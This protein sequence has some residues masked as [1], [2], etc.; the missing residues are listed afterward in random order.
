MS[1]APGTCRGWREGP[2][3]PDQCRVCYNERNGNP[4]APPAKTESLSRT[5][6]V[7]APCPHRGLI[8]LKRCSRGDTYACTFAG[9]EFRMCTPSNNVAL[10]IR[11]CL[12][13]PHRPTPDAWTR[14]LVYFVYPV[15]GNGV[16][17]DNIAEMA[18][19]FPLFNGTRRIA[20]AVG[21]NHPLDP[22]AAVIEAVGKHNA[23]FVIVPSRG[24][25]GEVAAFLPLWR[26]LLPFNQPNHVAFYGHAKGV[27][28]DPVALP[29]IRQWTD[30]MRR[31]NLDHWPRVAKALETHHTVGVFKGPFTSARRRGRI[32]FHFS[33]TYFWFKLAENFSRD[34]KRITE[35]YGGVERYLTN[36]FRTE[37]AYCLFG[38]N[39]GSMYDP[40]EVAR[41]E[42]NYRVWAA[43]EHD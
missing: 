42:E 26:R 8:P 32:R 19:R 7:I 31:A 23:D 21:G 43:I 35:G 1:H 13:C 29:Q 17:Q 40:A 16:W 10:D 14:H 30:L 6:P 25:V 4:S 3:T 9:H 11:S 24:N 15:A 22:P 33:G 12:N 34:W 5:H 38:E 27:T 28:R 36:V 41:Q 39:G 20:I 18:K 37:E 2:Y